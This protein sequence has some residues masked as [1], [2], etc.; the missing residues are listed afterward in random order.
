MSKE[1]TQHTIVL[2][3]M[4]EREKVLKA[5]S[6]CGGKPLH[7]S[8]ERIIIVEVPETV[9]LRK[10][11]PKTAKLLR[12]QDNIKKEISRPSEQ[13]LLFINSFKLKYSD[14]FIKEKKQRKSGSTPEEKAMLQESDFIEGDMDNY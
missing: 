11:L 14:A 12:L 9:K 13:E 2:R 4:K 7:N 8:N 1:K 6:K 3:D 10:E 5:L